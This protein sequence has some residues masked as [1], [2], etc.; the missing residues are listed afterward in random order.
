MSSARLASETQVMR[1]E[2]PVRGGP[3]G[4]LAALHKILPFEAAATSEW[5]GSVGVEAARWCELP[6][7]EFNTPALFHR[8]LVLF[9][10][11]P[12]ELDLRYEGVKRHVPH[13]AGSISLIGVGRTDWLRSLPPPNRAGGSPA[14]GSPVDGLTSERVD[15]PGRGLAPD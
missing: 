15:G 4:H 2:E 14:H 11:P 5:L 3:L 7:F 12:D 9:S 10:R 8:R 1:Q 13:P 6:A